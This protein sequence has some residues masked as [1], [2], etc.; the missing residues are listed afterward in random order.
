MGVNLTG[1]G[2]QSI[3][4]KGPIFAKQ[5]FSKKGARIELKIAFTEKGVMVGIGQFING[6]WHW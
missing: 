1:F 4:G 3:P 5:F 2:F 6:V